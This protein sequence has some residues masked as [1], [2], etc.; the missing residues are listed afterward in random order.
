MKLHKVR[1]ELD[2]HDANLEGS[3]FDDVNLH[4]VGPVRRLSQPRQ[5]IV[6][7]PFRGCRFGAAS[8]G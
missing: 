7:R 4:E 8:N 2:V 1:K 5:Q 6:A 3:R